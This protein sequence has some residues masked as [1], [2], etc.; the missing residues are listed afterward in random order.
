MV[1]QFIFSIVILTVYITIYLSISFFSISFYSEKREIFN[2][3][4]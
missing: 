1:F 4:N 2:G 3:K